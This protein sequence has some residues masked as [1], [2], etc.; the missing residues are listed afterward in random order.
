MINVFLKM[1]FLF[2]WVILIFPSSIYSSEDKHG[3]IGEPTVPPKISE[4]KFSNLSHEE[5]D[6]DSYTL[7]CLDSNLIPASESVNDLQIRKEFNPI[8]NWL[9]KELLEKIEKSTAQEE[10]YIVERKSVGGDVYYLVRLYTKPYI[11]PSE[12]LT[13][14]LWGG[15][16][17]QI[18]G[19]EYTRFPEGNK[20]HR[21]TQS[22]GS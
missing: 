5:N 9:R 7:V 13:T 20:G 1:F 14:R 22:Q 3:S 18:G 16:E 21:S 10:L 15:H 12:R 2:L 8:K 6:P 4:F 19:H 11:S 17:R